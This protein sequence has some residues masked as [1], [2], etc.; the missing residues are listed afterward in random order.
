MTITFGNDHDVIVYALKTIISYARQNQQIF[1]AQC[2]WWL[3]SII[4][5]EK[6]LINHIDNLGIRS[7]VAL[8]MTTPL[9]T[10]SKASEEGETDRQEKALKE[11]EEYLQ[12]S[13]R[14]RRLAKLKA[15][16]RT[17]TGRINLLVSTK[18]SL[19]ITTKRKGKQYSKT[20]GIEQTLIQRRKAEGECLRCVWPSDRKGKHWV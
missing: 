12:D 16:G 20:E 9:V 3:A 1:V 15:A 17:G 5:L 4:S 18:Q 11:C 19:K 6:G 7:S 8:P 14:L 2:V 13:Q 10:S